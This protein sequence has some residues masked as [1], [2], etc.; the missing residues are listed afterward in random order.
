MFVT[1]SI[2]ILY[3]NVPTSGENL[4]LAPFEHREI[5]MKILTS[6]CEIGFNQIFGHCNIPLSRCLQ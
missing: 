3:Q 1:S 4:K 5:I 6:P 2:V